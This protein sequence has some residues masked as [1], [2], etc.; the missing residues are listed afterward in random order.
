MKYYKTN[1]SKK[2]AFIKTKKVSLR[3]DLT[4]MV[5]LGFLL[6][7]FFVFTTTLAKPK[8]LT[9]NI[10]ADSKDSLSAPVSKILNLLLGANDNVFY[11]EGSDLNQIKKI[12]IKASDLRD[13]II[14][15]KIKL[16]KYSGD[17]SFIVLIKPT[18]D[19]TYANVINALDEMLI[20]DV[21]TYVLMDA[22]TEESNKIFSQP[23]KAAHS[24]I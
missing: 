22:S 1:E 11:Y 24:K 4:P 21:K 18:K 5:D 14:N 17:T 23:N 12:G 10:L 8:E 7:L 6:I 16:Q 19:A 20:N 13:V 3:I 15:K 9:L 2:Q